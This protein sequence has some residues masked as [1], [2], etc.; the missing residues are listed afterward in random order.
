MSSTPN[1]TFKKLYLLMKQNPLFRNMPVIPM[2]EEGKKSQPSKPSKPS[3]P[4]QSGQSGQS[5]QQTGGYKKGFSL[6]TGE[7]VKRVFILRGYSNGDQIDKNNSVE[8]EIDVV[9]DASYKFG[10]FQNKKPQEAAKKIYTRLC[11][12]S[13]KNS[14]IVASNSCY[15]VLMHI[16]EKCCDNTK[17]NN[18]VREYYYY[19]VNTPTKKNIIKKK[20]GRAI[21]VFNDIE[22]IPIFA[23][24]NSSNRKSRMQ[25]VNEAIKNHTAK[26]NKSIQVYSR[27][28]QSGKRLLKN[29]K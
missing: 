13:K 4:G 20:D 10:N 8:E 26:R 12:K 25:T 9:I 27:R 14:N 7:N 3:K 23:V 28:R 22:V 29:A 18:K 17:Q 19:V 24:R 16:E 21:N 2:F 6:K 11:K 15:S 1:L 5:G